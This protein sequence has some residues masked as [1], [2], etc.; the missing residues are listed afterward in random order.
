MTQRARPIVSVAEAILLCLLK[1]GLTQRGELEREMV[2]L[3]EVAPVSV[4]D[5]IGGLRQ[6]HLLKG[7][8]RRT[9][10]PPMGKSAWTVPVELTLKGRETAEKLAGVLR[11]LMP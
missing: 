9:G 1:R 5:A 10:R 7:G 4:R 8:T 2:R 3:L 11:G 6:V